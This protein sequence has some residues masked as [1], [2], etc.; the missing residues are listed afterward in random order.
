MIRSV[1]A[2]LVEQLEELLR[3]LRLLH[4]LG[5]DLERSRISSDG[6]RSTAGTSAR[7]RR[8]ARSS[9]HISAGS[10]AK[11]PSISTTRSPG[12]RV[13]ARPRRSGCDLRLEGA[14][15]RRGVLDVVRREAGRRDRVAAPAAV[16]DAERQPVALAGLVDRPV[17]APRPSARSCATA[18]APGRSAG[19]RPSGRSPRRRRARPRRRPRSRRAGAV[20]VEPLGGQPVVGGA[21]PSPRRAPGSASR[22]SRAAGSAPPPRCPTRRAAAPA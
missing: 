5:A 9:R 15:H 8:Q 21:W 12:K 2:E 4:R 22:R 20:A 18:P 7:S 11:P 17:P 3:P 6:G 14:G 10:H 13:E 16:V 1:H 19:R